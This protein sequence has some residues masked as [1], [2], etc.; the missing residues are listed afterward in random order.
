MN[1]QF[2]YRNGWQLVCWIGGP[3]AARTWL[4]NNGDSI[5]WVSSRRFWSFHAGSML[6]KSP[7]TVPGS[8]SAGYQPKPNPSP[9]T[10]SAPSGESSDC[11]TSECWGSKISF[12]GRSGSPRVRQPTTHRLDLLDP[13][14]R[15]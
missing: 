1:S 7:G 8:G 4:K 11:A 2:S 12:D 15:E 14:R 3:A 6:R 5:A 13:A 9:L 10:V